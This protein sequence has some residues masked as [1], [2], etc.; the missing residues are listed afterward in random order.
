MKILPVAVLTSLALMVDAQGWAQSPATSP[1]PTAQASPA[2]AP[3]SKR[4]RI[5]LCQHKRGAPLEPGA[6]Q[7]LSLDE[8]DSTISRP[9]LLHQVP[10]IGVGGSRG[11]S[12]VEAII[13][14]DGCV[15]QAKIAQTGGHKLDAAALSAIEQW[16]FLPAMKDGRPV[17]VRYFLT[18]ES[19]GL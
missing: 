11:K 6:S 18:L 10:P 13:D 7:P 8:L 2:P 17:R 1:A 5:K 12:I 4:E 15:R 9:T 19:T 16:V 3:L 14:E